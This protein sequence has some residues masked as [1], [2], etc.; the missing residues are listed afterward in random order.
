MEE[1][2]GQ[3]KE[4]RMKNWYIAGIA[5]GCLFVAATVL[6]SVFFYQT[7]TNAYDAKSIVLGILSSIADQFGLV[8]I[9]SLVFYSGLLGRKQNKDL[10]F[11]NM[12]WV[13]LIL[14]FYYVM[15]K[16][17]YFYNVAE[18]HSTINVQQTL[19]ILFSIIPQLIFA[20]F[21]VSFAYQGNSKSKKI[22]AAFAWLSVL[23]SAVGFANQVIF[24][25]VQIASG[26]KTMDVC[27]Y[28]MAA[29][30]ALSLFLLSVVFYRIAQKGEFYGM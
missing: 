28:A 27:Y 17:T 21:L 24:V 11:K 4:V 29:F 9:A 7:V 12:F 15:P 6:L 26:S 5:A 1:L 3:K 2:I 20:A 10:F 19:Y 16:L 23:A 8:V 18:Y 22:P 14:V 13:L 30:G 25:I